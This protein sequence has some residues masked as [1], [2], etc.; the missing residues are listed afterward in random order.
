MWAFLAPHGAFA[1][2]PKEADIISAA[3]DSQYDSAGL[4]K[5]EPQAINESQGAAYRADQLLSIRLFSGKFKSYK[6][7][8]YCKSSNAIEIT[9][10]IQYTFIVYMRRNAV[11]IIDKGFYEG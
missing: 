6:D 9:K 11:F 4:D 3:R 2:Q 5:L 8:K 10:C 1:Q 7:S